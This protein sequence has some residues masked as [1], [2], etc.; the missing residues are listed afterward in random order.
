MFEIEFVGYAYR[1]FEIHYFF[2]RGSGIVG[3]QRVVD[4]SAFYH[5][6]EFVGRYAHFMFYES[7]S[8]EG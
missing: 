8:D 2:H 1:F 4:K 5:D 7:F 3:M 6:E